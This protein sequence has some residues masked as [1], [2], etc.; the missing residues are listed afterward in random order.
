MYDGYVKYDIMYRNIVATVD[1]PTTPRKLLAYL[2]E[3]PKI[4]AW[5]EAVINHVFEL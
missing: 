5:K 3:I 2:K 1:V 4:F